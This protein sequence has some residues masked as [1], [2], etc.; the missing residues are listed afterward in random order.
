MARKKKNIKY[1]PEFR[2]VAYADG[3]QQS[4]VVDDGAA[5]LDQEEAEHIQEALSGLAGNTH[6]CGCDCVADT[7]QDTT[8][9]QHSYGQEQ[10]L[11][12]LLQISHHNK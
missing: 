3:E 10:S 1:S 8:N 11:A 4:H 7:H 2:S 9:G 12:E 5:G 6:N